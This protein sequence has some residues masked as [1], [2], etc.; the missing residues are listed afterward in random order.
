MDYLTFVWSF[1]LALCA[2]VCLIP[3]RHAAGSG[4]RWLGGAMICAAL[5][6]AWQLVWCGQPEPSALAHAPVF[7]IV[8]AA[9]L[10]VLAAAA[11]SRGTLPR[12]LAAVPLAIGGYLWIAPP[13]SGPMS[14]AH[15]AIWMPAFL[16]AALAVFMVSRNEGGESR[17]AHRLLAAGLAILATLKPMP[18]VYLASSQ[19]EGETL[20]SVLTSTSLLWIVVTTIACAFIVSGAWITYRLGRRAAFPVIDRRSGIRRG[21][22]FAFLLGSVLAVGWPLTDISSSRTDREWRDQLAQEA[23]LAASAINPHVLETLSAQPTDV[24]LPA[25]AEIKQRLALITKAGDGYRFAYLVGM[26]DGNVVFLADSEPV[27]SIDESVAGD[28]YG[29]AFENL[30]KAFGT[31]KPFTTGPDTDRWGTWISGYAPVPNS[32]LNGHPVFLGLDR[33]ASHWSRDLARMRQERMLVTLVFAIFIVGSF[34]INYIALEAKARQAASEDRLRLSLQ[35]ANLAS[36]EMDIPA[37]TISLDRAWARMAVPGAGASHLV[38]DDFLAQVH[39]DD[40]DAAKSGFGGICDGTSETMESE[41]RIARPGGGFTWVLNRGRVIQRG[42][43]GANLRA[44]GLLLDISQRKQTELE[45]ERRR[46]ESKRLALVAENT[47]NGVVITSKSGT[48]EWANSGF[49]RITGFSLDEVRGKRPGVFL[50]GPDTDKEVVARMRKGLADATGFHETVLNFTKSG[51]P[52]WIAIE[53]QALRDAD[54]GLSGFMAIES[55]VTARIEAERAL[56]DQ[57]H[58]LQQIN[59]ALLELGDSYGENIM[60]LTA[61]VGRIFGADRAVYHR[62]EGDRL[63]AHGRFG[64]PENYPQSCQASDSV[65]FDVIRSDEH[66][67]LLEGAA[68]GQPTDPRLGEFQTFVGQGVD[69]AGDIIGA[70][71]LS[72]ARPFRLSPDLRDCLSIIAQAV[73]REELLQQNRIRLDALAAREAT[74]RS[75]F[76]TLLQNMDD[77]VLVEDAKRIVT[78]ANPAFEKMFGVSARAIQGLHCDALATR[79]APLFSDSVGFLH[80]IKT[81]LAEGKS[82]TGMI[83]ETCDGRHL[84]RDFVPIVDKG[85]R[86]GYLWQYRDISRQRKSQILLEAIADVGQRVLSTP[87]NTPEAWGN[88]IALLGGK[89]GVDRVRV[90]HFFEDRM[91]SPS[92]FNVV[93]EWHRTGESSVPQSQ[94]FWN[95]LDSSGILTDWVTD[96]SRGKSVLECGSDAAAPVLKAMGTKSLLYLPLFVEGQ[97]WGAIGLHHAHSSYAWQEEEI[98]LLETAASL[99]SS[100]LDLQRS[101]DA[102]ISAKEAADA[103]S[104]AKSTFLATMSHEIRTPLNAV[105]GMSSLLMETDLEPQQRDY[106]GT[107]ATSAETLLDL[108]NDILDYSKIEA[109]RIEIEHAPFDLAEILVEPLEILARPAGEKKIELSYSLDH[110]LSQ[111][112]IGDR[113]RLKQVLLNLL[114][115]AVKFTARGEVSV[116][117]ESAGPSRVRFLVRDSGI[118]MSEEVQARLFQPF[119]Q[120]DSSVTRKFGGTG[121]GLAISKRLVELMHGTITVRSRPGEGTTFEIE[122]PL[123]PGELAPAHST[124]QLA[125]LRGARALIV[126]DNRTNR[127]FLRDQIGV[128]GMLAT[129]ADGAAAALELLRSN[130][131]FDVFLLDYQMPEMDGI[132]LARKIRAIPGCAGIPA[133]LLSSIVEKAPPGDAHLFAEVVTK[134]LRPAHLFKVVSKVLGVKKAAAA[135]AAVPPAEHPARDLRVLVAE[136]NPTNQKVIKMMLSRVGIKPTIVANG[137]EAVDA[138][139]AAPFDLVLMDVQMA[140]MDGLAA[141]ALMRKHFGDR[142]RPE[143]IALTANAFKEDREACIAAGMDGY[144]VKPI[145]LDRLKTV[146]DRVRDRMSQGGDI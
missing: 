132:E 2:L 6:R 127:Q 17:G 66:F 61:L 68:A 40:R 90:L 82:C 44:A 74:Q 139:K 19:I 136:D 126:D 35:G 133:V 33:T 64:T 36:W 123:P 91:V 14:L 46:E 63:V 28:V 27:G 80:S 125:S 49:T 7:L 93:A 142:S 51:R 81:A 70:I 75:R 122:I 23:Q 29:D 105:I 79:A 57:R 89:V 55:D 58:R 130:T 54:G 3:N 1:L 134:P 67:L 62:L 48:I 121:L 18:S 143:I 103:A 69:L 37:R 25:Y 118:G 95:V 88:L 42:P 9:V 52:Y 56:E 50:Q 112:V 145:T 20:R 98:T 86:Y 45:L 39:P 41:F 113:T 120:A 137:L 38:C 47:T 8:L 65:S 94:E 77:A 138:V 102:L 104:R 146:I 26:R 71:G 72:F 111:S 87:L 31:G 84:S 34:A 106:A 107:V 141:A 131:G 109:G 92:S 115:N 10:A 101:E 59:A 100:R 114:S 12:V 129:E 78:F 60:R 4:W 15:W 43:Q 135:A 5:L 97:F 16:C 24:S 110:S 96:L 144:V 83:F 116:R 85:V 21:W 53:C 99:I 13:A 117:A 30:L 76:S 119:M 22:L 108:I 140:V 128:W 124:A 11:F 73:G 32:A